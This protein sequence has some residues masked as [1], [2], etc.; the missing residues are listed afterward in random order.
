[1]LGSEPPKEQI[2]QCYLSPK[3]LACSLLSS[4]HVPH[5]SNTFTLFPYFLL[6]HLLLRTSVSTTVG[7]PQLFK[8]LLL[9]LKKL[10]VLLKNICFCSRNY[11]TKGLLLCSRPY[12]CCLRNF[13]SK[14][15][16]CWRTCCSRTGQSKKEVMD[17]CETD[18]SVWEQWKGAKREYIGGVWV[19]L[20]S[21]WC[22]SWLLKVC[23]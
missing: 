20:T 2:T 14:D 12:R 21:C 16:C 5:Y 17:I 11:A 7:E 8:A 6:S 1:V 9:L 23:Y 19:A 4:L 15:L 10:L 22:E 13:D 18:I 3:V